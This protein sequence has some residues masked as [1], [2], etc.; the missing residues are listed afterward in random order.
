MLHSGQNQTSPQPCQLAPRVGVKPQGKTTR[1]GA[2]L[3]WRCLGL[4]EQVEDGGQVG[5]LSGKRE[6]GSGRTRKSLG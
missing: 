5:T 4:I 2:M 3:S 6:V 1:V